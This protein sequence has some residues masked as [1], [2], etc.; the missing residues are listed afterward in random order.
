MRKV[1]EYRRHAEDCRKLA[2]S[3]STEEAKQQ[4]LQM[5]ETWDALAKNREEQIARGHRVAHSESQNG[6]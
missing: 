2:G 6:N 1:E 5:A 3:V 4:L